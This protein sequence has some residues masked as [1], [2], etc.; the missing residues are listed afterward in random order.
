V[1]KSDL[2]KITVENIGFHFFWF[3]FFKIAKYL[4]KNKLSF[5]VDVFFFFWQKIHNYNIW[6][7]IF[8]MSTQE[9]VSPRKS[10]ISKCLRRRVISIISRKTFIYEIEFDCVTFISVPHVT[11]FN[12]QYPLINWEKAILYHGSTAHEWELM[13]R[14]ERAGIKGFPWIAEDIH[15]LRRLT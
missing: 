8:S 6:H 13:L 15:R 2:K 1:T 12:I 14:D 5:I 7:K 10:N 3:S 11:R 9:Y 4:Q